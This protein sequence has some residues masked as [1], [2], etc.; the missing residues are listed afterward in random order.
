MFPIFSL[1]APC[2]PG[3]SPPSVLNGFQTRDTASGWF[4]TTGEVKCARGASRVGRDLEAAH[5]CTDSITSRVGLRRKR[6]ILDGR[7]DMIRFRTALG[8]L[9]LL[10]G[11]TPAF[12]QQPAAA[13]RI[14]V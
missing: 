1:F 11:A 4:S 9:A 13:G 5:I 7:G 10:F 3:A 12:S 6:G 8:V 14:K 2:H